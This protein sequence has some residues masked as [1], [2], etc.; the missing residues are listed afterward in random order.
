MV[1]AVTIPRLSLCVRDV[2]ES[3]TYSAMAKTQDLCTSEAVEMKD[4]TGIRVF[5]L[6]VERD[7]YGE[8]G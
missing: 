7:A 1:R 4:C 8:G 5:R 6:C 2:E 3:Q